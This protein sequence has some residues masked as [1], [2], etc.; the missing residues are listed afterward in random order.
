MRKYERMHSV[1]SFVFFECFNHDTGDD[2]S[3]QQK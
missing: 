1:I 3:M 2:D